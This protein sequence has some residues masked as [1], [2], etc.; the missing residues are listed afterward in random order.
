MNYISTNTKHNAFIHTGENGNDRNTDAGCW[1]NIWIE[2]IQH[3]IEWTVENAAGSWTYGDFKDYCL[4]E[5]K[6]NN[7]QDLRI[8]TNGQEI[9]SVDDKVLL[10]HIN[11][12]LAND[13]IYV[14]NATHESKSLKN[15]PIVVMR[16][17][18]TDT[19]NYPLEETL[20]INK[21]FT[22]GQVKDELGKRQRSKNSVG[23]GGHPEAVGVLD[24][25]LIHNGRY[26]HKDK[27]IESYKIRPNEKM[28]AVSCKYG[29]NLLQFMTWLR[30]NDLQ[31]N[32]DIKEQ[33][34][35]KDPN[36]MR[37]GTMNVNNMNPSQITI[38]DLQESLIAA[39]ICGDEK[40]I[41]HAIKQGKKKID[42]LRI[43]FNNV[44]T[45]HGGKMTPQEKVGLNYLQYFTVLKDSAAVAIYLWTTN[46]LYKQVNRALEME[47]EQN[48]KAFKLYLNVLDYG[49][50]QLPYS[51]RK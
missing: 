13:T 19:T 11:C 46:L 18:D 6:I 34:N 38:S 23:D 32:G 4:K 7:G 16:I 12:F 45:A 43:V 14:E 21:H 48:L 41:Q 51:L 33:S 29:G 25:I 36:S 35:Y 22:I 1:D 15:Y 28:L 42:D 37:S 24:E 44:K 10:K 9:V 39:K 26:L 50:R 27:T 49:L 20:N 8:V 5:L 30:R 3:S 31:K 17:R 47:I 2:G 40:L